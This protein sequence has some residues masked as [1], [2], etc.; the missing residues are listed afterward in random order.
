[1]ERAIVFE[2]SDELTFEGLQTPININQPMLETAWFKPDFRFPPEGFALES[3]IGLLIPTCAE[4][5]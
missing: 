5:N 3:A 1:M 2:E 4:T